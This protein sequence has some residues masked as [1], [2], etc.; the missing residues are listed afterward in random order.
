M[1]SVIIPIKCGDNEQSRLSG[2]GSRGNWIS[3]ISS[4]RLQYHVWEAK[5]MNSDSE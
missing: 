5:H 1:I 3:R 2:L 4:K